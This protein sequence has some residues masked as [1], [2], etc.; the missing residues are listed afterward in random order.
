MLLCIGILFVMYTYLGYYVTVPWLSCTGILVVMYRY[1]GWYVPVYLCFHVPVCWL[2]CTVILIIM[3]R[4]LCC[5]V[6]VSWLLCIDILAWWSVPR[7]SRDKGVHCACSPYIQWNRRRQ[8]CL[9]APDISTLTACEVAFPARNVEWTL[10]PEKR[11]GIQLCENL[12][13]SCLNQ[14]VKC[15]I[16]FLS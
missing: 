6:P 4:H 5:Y 10:S 8:W 15:L 2:L 7:Q 12:Q 9:P 11:Y 3:N 16:F 1:L 13:M 14:T